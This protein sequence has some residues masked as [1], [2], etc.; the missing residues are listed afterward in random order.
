[1]R[2]W[3]EKGNVMECHPKHKTQ[4]PALGAGCNGSTPIQDYS[5]RAAASVQAKEVQS[6]LQRHER[7]VRAHPEKVA[8]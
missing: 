5:S 6:E 7:A 1:M 4:M 8:N 2:N 3:N